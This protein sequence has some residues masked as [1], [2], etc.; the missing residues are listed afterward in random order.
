MENHFFKNVE[1]KTGVNMNEILAL[2]NSLQSANFKDEKTVR[3]IIKR[4]SQIANKPVS[5]EMEDKMVKSI[6]QDGNN[7]DMEAISKM[8]NK[9]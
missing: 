4:V 1:K 6:I 8:M 9:R 3:S 7:L 5:K 2:A